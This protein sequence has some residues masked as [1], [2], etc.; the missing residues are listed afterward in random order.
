MYHDE[1]MIKMVK[2]SITYKLSGASMVVAGM[3]SDAQELLN[4]GQQDM[5]NAQ[6]N[7]AKEVLFAIMDGELVGTVNRD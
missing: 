1:Q 5:A 3:L 4:A 6:V 2:N 7:K